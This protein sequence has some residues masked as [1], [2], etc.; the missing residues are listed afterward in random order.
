MESKHT[1]GPWEPHGLAIYTRD[2]QPAQSSPGD[3]RERQVAQALW[4][5]DEDDRE[6]AWNY[7]EAAANARLIAASP[8]L[9]HACE[10]LCAAYR[11]GEESGGS[12]EWSDVDA[13]WE[14]AK[15]ALAKA[16]GE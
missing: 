11:A 13:A 6:V 4:D 12:I 16:R 2:K 9:A 10:L 3:P 8:D 15:S 7:E 1:P 5:A 14:A